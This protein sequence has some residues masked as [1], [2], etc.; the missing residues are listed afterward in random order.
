MSDEKKAPVQVDIGVKATAELKAEVPSTSIGRL[1][2]ALTDAI[3]PFTEARGLR[4]DQIR[5]QREDVLIQIAEKA[6]ARSAAEGKELHAVP[7]KLLVPF[8][9]KASLEIDDEELRERWAALLLSA[10]TSYDARMLSFLD[11]LT[12]ISSQEALLLEDVC[13]RVAHFPETSYP[14]GHV[15]ENRQKI[16]GNCRRLNT[17]S[18]DHSEHRQLFERF[19]SGTQLKYGGVIYATTFNP[20]VTLY[21]YAKGALPGDPFYDSLSI[22]DRERLIEF[23]TAA[24]RGTGVQVGYFN[25]TRLGIQ[26]VQ[27][28]G[29]RPGTLKKAS[30]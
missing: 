5:L 9:E 2:D 19:V 22:L 10:S 3:R 8:L 18:T 15:D 14:G 20:Q 28:C 12:R 13:Y 17:A 25:V 24:P 16:E 4:A 29:V 7:P 27:A 1:V 6:R 11:I 21:H 23:H 26:F 30:T